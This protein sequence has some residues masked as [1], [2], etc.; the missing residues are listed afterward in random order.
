MKKKWTINVTIVKI[1]A[2][3]ENEKSVRMICIRADIELFL[4][5]C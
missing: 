3:Y 5:I 4:K 2:L 1:I